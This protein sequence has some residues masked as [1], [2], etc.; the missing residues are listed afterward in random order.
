MLFYGSV[1]FKCVK[2][3]KVETEKVN[4]QERMTKLN[5]I[6]DSPCQ[7]FNSQPLCFQQNFMTNDLGGGEK[8]IFIKLI[9]KQ[10]FL[11]LFCFSGK[12]TSTLSRLQNAL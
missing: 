4:A 5:A 10:G 9:K 11:V 3:F 1:M 8:E 12:S 2:C 6:I 7:M